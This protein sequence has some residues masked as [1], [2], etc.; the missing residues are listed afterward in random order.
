[1]ALESC[2][3]LPQ[4]L[5][6]LLGDVPLIR[7]DMLTQFVK[8]AQQSG[9]A[10][11]LIAMRPPNPKGYGRVILGPSGLPEAIRED[12]DLS[13]K[14]Q[15]LDL[16]HSGIFFLGADMISD[17]SHIP[18]ARGG[19]YYLTHLVQTAHS[20]D[21]RTGMMEA[22]FA[23]LQGVNTRQQLAEAEGSIQNRLRK[24]VM[25][26]GVTL[27]DPSSSH[28][29]WDTKIGPDTVLYPHV[30]LGPGVVLEEGVTV[31]PFSCLSHTHARKGA[32][33]GPC[34]HLRGGVELGTDVKVGSFVEVKK[35]TLGE[36]TSAAHL[37][38]IGDATLGRHVNVGAGTITCNYNGQTKH[39]TYIDDDAFLGSNTSLIAPLK[40]GAKALIGAGSVITK[41]VPKNTLALERGEQI[42]KLRK[43]KKG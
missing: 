25:D 7:E 13:E 19:E 16:C 33:I 32:R 36:K 3:A 43:N 8:G 30:V 10:L 20:K 38:Y 39:E 37:T 14:E 22:P 34:A 24:Q 11:S 5:L 21:L 2:R 31:F 27:M 28:L 42:M 29:S 15:D 17:I 18:Q 26:G 1:M 40:I 41:D 6:V 23:E 35:S 9:S 4:N 12:V